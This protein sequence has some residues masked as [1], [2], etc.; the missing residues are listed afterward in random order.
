MIET[1]PA[2]PYGFARR[3]GVVLEDEDAV[4]LREGA[5][6]EI[7]IE[8]RRHLG[9]S[10]AVKP[11]SPAAFDEL[12]SSV[13]AMD[14]AAAAMAAGSLGADS[15]LDLIAK[16]LLICLRNT[17]NIVHPILARLISRI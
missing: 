8:V 2:L 1:L 16:A 17:S 5:D 14:G 13:Y 6:P 7:L 3:H 10:F 15:A 9:R 12:L 4:A 11:V